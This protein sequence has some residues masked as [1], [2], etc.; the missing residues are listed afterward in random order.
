MPIVRTPSTHIH[1]EIR[2][3]GGP[4]GGSGENGER[5]VVLL[6]GLGLSSRYWFDAPSRLLA[7]DPSRRVVLVDNRGTGQSGRAPPFGWPPWTVAAMA[8]DVAA[9]LADAGIRRAIIVGISMGGM[10]AQHVALRHPDVAS[11]LVLLATSPGVG[12]AVPPRPGAMALL[13]S[14]PLGGSRASR[15]LVRLLLPPSKWESAREIFRDWPNVMRD[16]PTSSATFAAHLFAAS[17][18]YVGAELGRI[19][20]PVVVAAGTEDVLIPSKNSE[21][22]AKRIPNAELVLVEGAG[23]ALVAEDRDLL[24]RLVARVEAR[25]ARGTAESAVGAVT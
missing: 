1:Y 14:L 22:L 20:C 11:G 12:L 3:G 10:I 15:S 2:G 4:E 25:V 5:A 23:H 21:K 24:G 19:G 13:M 7:S 6:Q 9:V 18:H 8:D 17:T 16:D